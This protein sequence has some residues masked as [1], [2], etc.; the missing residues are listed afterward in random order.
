MVRRAGILVLES[1]I[2]GHFV[3]PNCFLFSGF[4]G[5]MRAIFALTGLCP[6][7][8]ILYLAGA[9]ERCKC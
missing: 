5:A 7:S 8:I 9:R 2:L 6:M 1:T 4:A 3:R